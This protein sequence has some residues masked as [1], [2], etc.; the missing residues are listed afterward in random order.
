[1]MRTMSS[2]QFIN[3]NPGKKRRRSD[4][5]ESVEDEGDV[6]EDEV[7]DESKNAAMGQRK[8]RHLRTRSDN[9]LLDNENRHPEGSTV[10][11]RVKQIDEQQAEKA[12]GGSSAPS[13]GPKF[14]NNILRSAS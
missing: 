9:F 14:A 6:T 5:K 11:D 1:M 12:T 10:K 13:I 2:I 4:V 8:I 7:T 3:E